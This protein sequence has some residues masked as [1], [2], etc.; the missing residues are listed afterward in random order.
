MGQRILFDFVQ[1]CCKTETTDLLYFRKIFLKL[2]LY[3]I[4]LMHD[5]SKKY[6]LLRILNII[7]VSHLILLYKIF[8]LQHDHYKNSSFFSL[9]WY[10]FNVSPSLI[11]RCDLHPF[12]F[13]YLAFFCTFLT[14][15]H[16]W[17]WVKRITLMKIIAKSVVGLE[18]TPQIS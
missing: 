7:V 12:K 5:F 10:F 1:V 14:I 4:R 15:S 11:S 16:T 17:V 2:I 13:L 8:F 9:S 18:E 3:L 6:Y